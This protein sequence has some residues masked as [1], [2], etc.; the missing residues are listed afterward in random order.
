[1]KIDPTIRYLALARRSL[2]MRDEKDEKAAPKRAAV[3]RRASPA[4]IVV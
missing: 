2:D 1:V 3:V 4:I